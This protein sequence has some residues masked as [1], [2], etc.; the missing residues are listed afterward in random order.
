M[1]PDFHTLNLR[2]SPNGDQF[3][4][5]GDLNREG[6]SELVET[7]L[8]TQIGRGKDNRNANRQENYNIQLKWYPADDKIEVNDDTGNKGLRDGILMRFLSTLEE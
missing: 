5:K 4:V 7:F 1:S 6:Q 2:Y 8:R 3:E